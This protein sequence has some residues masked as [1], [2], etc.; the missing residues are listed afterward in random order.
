MKYLIGYK[1]QATGALGITVTILVEAKNSG[2][3]K[4][5]AAKEFTERQDCF[6]PAGSTPLTITADNVKEVC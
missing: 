3:A 2:E 1:A 5:K 6:S 4:V